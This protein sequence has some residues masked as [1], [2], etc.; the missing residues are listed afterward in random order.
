M[1]TPAQ[2]AAALS[3]SERQVSRLTSA[4]MPCQPVGVRGKRY[5]LDECRNRLKDALEAG[6]TLEEMK[7]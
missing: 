7:V 2:L 3:I 5:V 1:L 4:G 6:K